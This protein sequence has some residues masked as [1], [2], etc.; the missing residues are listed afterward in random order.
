LFDKI[1][2]YTDIYQSMYAV[3]SVRLRL[4]VSVVLRRS[5]I[6]RYPVQIDMAGQV[7]DDA[8]LLG[9]ALA[10]VKLQFAQMRRFLVGITFFNHI[11]TIF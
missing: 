6:T 1:Y 4:Y 7:Q 10:I 9:E 2:W 8:K 11:H 3:G 5:S